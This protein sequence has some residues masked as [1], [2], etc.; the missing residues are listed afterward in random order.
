MEPLPR[1]R[2]WFLLERKVKP[3]ELQLFTA[4]LPERTWAFEVV[5]TC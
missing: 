2:L 3:D 1:I 4:C 5:F